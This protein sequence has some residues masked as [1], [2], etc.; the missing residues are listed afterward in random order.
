MFNKTKNT[1]KFTEN[2]LKGVT[3][4]FAAMTPH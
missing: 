4:E 1:I 2:I 3:K